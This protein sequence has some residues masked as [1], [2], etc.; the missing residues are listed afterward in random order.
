[1]SA[2]CPS[3]LWLA[4]LSGGVDFLAKGAPWH[5]AFVHTG[6]LHLDS[7]FV[8][9]TTEAPTTV[10]KTLR[11]STITAWNNVIE[12]AL[13]EAADFLVVAGDAFEHANRTLRGQLVFRDGLDP[14]LGCRH[15]LVRRH[16]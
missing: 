3:V 10:V 8:G 2:P 12:L 7:P 5:S 14:P 9:L 15:P 16:R 4:G 6:D 11:E 13:D 1:M